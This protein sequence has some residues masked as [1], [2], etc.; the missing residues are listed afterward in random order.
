MAIKKIKAPIHTWKPTKETNFVDCDGKLFII[1]FD[2]IFG[3]NELSMY[4]KF[5]IK[6][7]SYENQLD[8]IVKYANF[9]MNNYD[10]E[11]EL[12]LAYIKLKQAIDKKVY[13]KDNMNALISAIYEIMFTPSIIEKIEI[14]TEENYLDDIE[15]SDD[16]KAYSTK[17]K[18]HLE[19]LEFTNQHIKL[20]LEISFCMKIMSPVIFHY[21]AINLIKLEKDSDY[22]FRFYEKL[23]DIFGKDCNMY[24]KLFIYV[25]A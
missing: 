19:S 20:L 21:F 12:A 22:I 17:D 24:N 10:P 1:H 9:F 18:K 8:I 16:P 5:M 23:F 11:N 13:D 7:C 3:I 25:N 2:K 15:S 4:N 14:M 6:K